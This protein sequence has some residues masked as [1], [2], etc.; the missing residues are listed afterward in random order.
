M[1]LVALEHAGVG[2]VVNVIRSATRTQHLTIRPTQRN[3]EGFAVLEVG[4]VE[5]RFLKGGWYAFHVTTLPGK[6]LSVKYIYALRSGCDCS[7]LISRRGVLRNGRDEH[8]CILQ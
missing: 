5:D 6:V 1:L 4:K 2:Q 3:H 8:R 7:T